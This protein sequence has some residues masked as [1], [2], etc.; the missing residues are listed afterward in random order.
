[1]TQE[2]KL[3]KF[4]TLYRPKSEYSLLIGLTQS[5]NFLGAVYK[6]I[7]IKSVRYKTTDIAESHCFYTNVKDIEQFVKDLTPYVDRVEIKQLAV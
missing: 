2:E 4:K 5:K 6:K 3:T 7:E 1:M